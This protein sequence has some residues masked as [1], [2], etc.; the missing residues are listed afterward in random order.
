M[1]PE[2]PQVALS[3]DEAKVHQLLKEETHIAL[4]DLKPRQALAIKN[5]IRP[6]KG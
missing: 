2:Q 1:K 5:G 4:A 6:S 3:E